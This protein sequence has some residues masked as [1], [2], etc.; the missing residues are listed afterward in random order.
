MGHL[1]YDSVLQRERI[2]DEVYKNS[3]REFHDVLYL[4][5]EQKQ[6]KLNLETRVCVVEAL[7]RPWRDMGIPEDAKCLGD[8]VIGSDDLPNA[9]LETNNWYGEHKSEKGNNVRYMLQYTNAGCLPV[10]AVFITESSGTTVLHF[11]DIK[12]GIKCPY[13]FD[14]PKECL[15]KE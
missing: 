13:A 4:H 6:Y 12:L 9:G 15:G 8:S 10:S 5:K 11:T 14:I 2:I 1:L 7:T 3:T